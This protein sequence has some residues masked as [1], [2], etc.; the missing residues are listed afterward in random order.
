M[1]PLERRRLE[2]RHAQLKQSLVQIGYIL[3]GSVV[4]RFMPCGRVSC[5]CA[6]GRQ[7]YHGPYYQWSV[8]LQGRPSAV[9]LTSEQAQ[10]YREWTQNN[11]KVRSILDGMRNISMRLVEHQRKA[12]SRR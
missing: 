10:L 4:K 1:T 2:K 6:A 3:P 11:Q 5:R 9:R 8:A 12:M 7:H